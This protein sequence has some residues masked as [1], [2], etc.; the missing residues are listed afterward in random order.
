M[1]ST[2]CGSGFV[3]RRKDRK[4]TQLFWKK[5]ASNSKTLRG[6]LP[7]KRCGG[8]WGRYVWQT[9]FKRNSEADPDK[10]EIIKKG[11]TDIKNLLKK[12]QADLFGESLPELL[13]T[14]EQMRGKLLTFLSLAE[15]FRERYQLAKREKNIADFNDLEQMALEILVKKDGDNFVRTQAAEELSEQFHEIMIDEY[16]DSNLVQEL[17]LGSVAKENN[18]FM[19]GDIKQSIYRFRNARPDLFLEKMNTFE[20]TDGAEKPALSF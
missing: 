4:N 17:L 7:M 5:S 19:V 14:M 12:M 16:Q 1:I 13:V 11:R 8:G 2:S 10:K 15:K 6:F 9:A 3:I 18:R 20:T